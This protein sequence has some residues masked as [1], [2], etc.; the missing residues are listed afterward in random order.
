MAEEVKTQWHPAFCSAMKLELMEDDSY[1]EHQSEYH[2]NTKPLQIDLLIIKKMEEVELKNEI[3]KMFRRHNL[4]EY[5]S[6]EDT[7]N[8]GTFLKIVAYACLYK[9][10]E[11]HVDDIRLEEITLTLVREAKPMKLFCW[12][13]EH[14]Y[15]IR[16]PFPGI[17]YI[18]RENCFPTQILVSKELSKENQKWLTLLSSNLDKEDVTRTA[19]QMK[20]LTE[21]GEK[22]FG[23]SILQV[24]MKENQDVFNKMKEGE[25]MCQALREFF[26]DELNEAL[27]K[28]TIQ[29]TKQVTEQN[30]KDIISNG[31]KKGFDVKLICELVGVSA[32]MVEAVKQEMLEVV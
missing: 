15:R 27:E 28:R 22:R 19:V 13:R 6:P 4:V 29:V 24:V 18:E 23:D 16:K 1:L 25:I 20:T 10:Y 3:G 17:Y 9:T 7:L 30:K 26:A 31:L 32:E 5:K 14:H 12:F 11:E 21:T 2:L 8:L